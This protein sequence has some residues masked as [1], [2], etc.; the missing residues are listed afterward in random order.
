MQHPPQDAKG[1]TGPDGAIGHAIVG[2]VDS[3]DERSDSEGRHDHRVPIL[4]VVASLTAIVDGAHAMGLDMRHGEPQLAQIRR[5]R[6]RRGY[7]PVANRHVG[8]F[9][10]PT[11]RPRAFSD[12]DEGC[13][14]SA[15]ARLC[16]V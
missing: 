9:T 15:A 6:A 8:I 13:P 10:F 5:H 7:R 3:V 4:I 16:V 1:V 12:G 14:W 2:F 11:R